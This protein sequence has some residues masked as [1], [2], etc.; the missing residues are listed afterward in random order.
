MKL[1]L[2]RRVLCTPYNHA[3]CHFMQSHTRKVY[4]C[5]AVTCHLRF[6]QN[7]RDLLR[8]TAV[9]RGWNGY[10]NNSQ[11]RKLTLEKKIFP[12]LCRDSNP[13]PLNHESDVLTTE[14]SLLPIYIYTY[15]KYEWMSENVRMK[16]KIY[17]IF[18]T[19]LACLQRQMHNAS[20][21]YITELSVYL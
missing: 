15:M 3:P 14:L 8:S 10:G 1:L 17:I 12:P 20:S 18:H 6:W 4:V 2:S 11:H 5:W 9:I 16:L 21:E 7:D 19:K 13:R